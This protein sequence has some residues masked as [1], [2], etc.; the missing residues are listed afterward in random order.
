[1]AMNDPS[2]QGVGQFVPNCVYPHYAL[3][4]RGLPAEI[5]MA[6]WR[7]AISSEVRVGLNHQQKLIYTTTG[8]LSDKKGVKTLKP[9]WSKSMCC[10]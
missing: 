1:M 6:I 5:R 4:Y 2:T 10:R 7:L 3:A 9:Y 8:C